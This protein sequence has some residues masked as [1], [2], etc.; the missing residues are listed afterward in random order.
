MPDL[1]LYLLQV[2]LLPDVLYYVSEILR[3]HLL[4]LARGLTVISFL[5]VSF[6]R[7]VLITLIATP[8]PS[9]TAIPRP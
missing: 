3:F 9:L 4:P 5:S 7:E 1:P 8:D 6:R 2:L